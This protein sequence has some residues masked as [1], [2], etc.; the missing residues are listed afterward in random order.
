[1]QVQVILMHAEMF[2]EGTHAL[3]GSGAVSVRELPYS[4]IANSLKVSRKHALGLLL[5]RPIGSSRELERVYVALL[6]DWLSFADSGLKCFIVHTRQAD[7]SVE[8]SQ[9]HLQSIAVGRAVYPSCCCPA[10]SR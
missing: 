8:L 2:E 6:M 1:M 10:S 9:R 3:Y 4:A 5:D 7:S